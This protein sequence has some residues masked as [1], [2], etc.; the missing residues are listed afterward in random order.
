[1]KTKCAL[2]LFF[3]LAP[4]LSLQAAPYNIRDFGAQGDGKTLNTQ[5]IQKAIDSCRSSGG[6]TV[7]I[8]AGSY[9]TGTLQ[10]YSN[11]DLH[12]EQ[13][14]VLKG[15][16]KVADSY[17]NGQKVGLIYTENAE[18]V[19][20][21]GLG[22]IDGN[23]DAFMDLSQAKTM[24]KESLKYT[25]QKEHFRE[26]LHG[27]GD[28]PVVPLDRPF[29][30]IIFSNCKNVTVRGL[31]ISQSPFWTV[32]FADC[33]G[34]VVSGI[35]LW[36]NLMVAN[37]DGLD[38][39]SCSHVM[40]SDCDIRAGDDAI[41]LAGYDHHFDLPGYKRI[42][43]TSE[44]IT[45]TNCSLQSRSSGIR[46]GGADQNGMQNYVFSNLVISGSNRGIGV[47]LRD[48]GSIEDVTFNNIIIKTR[49]HTGDW[50][51]NGEPI[52]ISAIRNAEKVKM[53]KIRNLKFSHIIAEGESGLLIYGTPE[54]I[55][56][57][58][59]FHD[60]SFRLRK[61]ALNPIAGGNFDL[62]PVLDNTLQLFSHDIP[63]IYAQYVKDLEI[64]DFDLT[65]EDVQEPFFTH[66]LDIEKFENLLI[67]G[68]HGGPAPQNKTANAVFLKEGRYYKIIESGV[69]TIGKSRFLK[70]EKVK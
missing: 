39:T 13:G 41:V 47:F 8:P 1:M 26:V 6:G 48:E 46:I 51:G 19:S 15:S 45:V 64:H 56:E 40:I 61:S 62:R 54:S 16:P 31:L 14:A 42:K 25:R 29:Q 43:H 50:W 53:G 60:V 21:T 2:T 18:N 32:H 10:L 7:L 20:L 33:D 22:N 17:L 70:T 68:F 23:G 37:G 63:G 59:T 9:L 49:L 11:I 69:H 35:R 44:D 5:A 57:K 3:C 38:F 55:I 4:V 34:V 24:G 58:L 12:L 30:M 27:L 66:G 65:W 52:H 67:Q 36:N 28:G